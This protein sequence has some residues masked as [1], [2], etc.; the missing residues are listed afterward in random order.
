MKK[1][2]KTVIIIILVGLS[3]AGTC[4]LFY[5]NLV[6]QQDAY[7]RIN[8]YMYSAD[9][10]NTDTNLELVNAEASSRLDLAMDTIDQLDA[11]T[12]TLNTYMICSLDYDVDN[13]KIIER[14]DLA[15]EK[16]DELYLDTEEFIL[17][18]TNEYFDTSLG[19]NDVIRTAS[20]YIIRYAD[21]IQCMNDEIRGKMVINN[22]DVKFDMIELYCLTT[23]DA[24][25]HLEDNLGLL[26]VKNTSNIVLLNNNFNL[27]NGA[28]DTSASIGSEYSHY[29][30]KFIEAYNSVD[31]SAFASNL[32][33]NVNAVNGISSNST[34]VQ[35]ATYYLK[36]ILGL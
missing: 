7:A 29:N 12:R 21:M 10:T 19:A 24:F 34:N 3:V 35:K 8:T 2:L 30:N 25:S 31:K 23:I 17:K 32:Y 26:G 36:Q 18:T 22:V 16:R 27:V 9:K 28:V 1:A 4:Y 20:S 13:N 33:A 6:Q 5:A 11:I 15:I 14:L